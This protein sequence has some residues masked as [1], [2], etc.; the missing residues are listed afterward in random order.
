MDFILRLTSITYPYS[1]LLE[2]RRASALT[3]LV[4]MAVG[5]AIGILAVLVL[6]G[7]DT[8][9]EQALL[10]MS[11]VLVAT[12]I[13]T[14]YFGNRGQLRLASWIYVGVSMLAS[15]TLVVL[16]GLNTTTLMAL[17]I[18]Y[19]VGG[20]V[21]DRRGVV[22]VTAGLL[23]GLVVAG[24]LELTVFNR[25]EDTLVGMIAQPALLLIFFGI[26]EWYLLRQ[27]GGSFDLI[28]Q[29]EHNLNA[30]YELSDIILE[31][32][33]V[34]N[35]LREYALR[36]QRSMDLQQVL[37]YM[38]DE[39]R[40]GTLRLRAAA[41]LAAQRAL[42]DERT[43]SLTSEQPV[44]T[45]AKT[46][47]PQIGRI[48]DLANTRS[49]FFPGTNAE[50]AIP[51]L[52]GTRLLGVIDLHSAF[53]DAFGV[54]EVESNLL[55]S[56]QLAFV[57][58][59]LRLTAELEHASTDQSQ[60]QRQIAQ[61]SAEAQR[62]RRQ[63]SGT[64]WAEFFQT[65]D[66]GG[67]GFDLRREDPE[68]VSGQGLTPA[69]TQALETGQVQVE[70][71]A[72]GHR[73]TLPILMRGETLGAMEFDIQRP[74]FLPERLVELASTVAERLSLSLDNA[75]LVEQAQAVAF[76]EQQVS[77][78]SGRLQVTS[79]M[80]ELITLAA[81]EFSEALDGASTHIRMQI[82][83]TPDS[84]QTPQAVPATGQH[85]GGAA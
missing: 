33:S 11:P 22:F 25:L 40:P 64:V 59:N 75:R 28:A 66:R 63:T 20:L 31:A 16:S 32:D 39:N 36:A 56:R 82:D 3:I 8:S 77:N 62:L 67:L 5:L 29:M 42:L 85:E 30:S 49:G 34:D 18:P 26:A 35:L 9:R 48:T 60:L 54:Q 46:H 65:R 15:L 80:E 41:G 45:A 84:S 69:M 74:G 51:L 44:T 55:I 17:A 43:L 78:I 72:Q 70:P 27:M 83:D 37:I 47:E 21:L 53:V 52:E 76:R 61:L 57:L 12:A 73:L 38:V 19:F 10:L 2:Q 23:G 14:L 81:A 68:P 24:V 71:T 58:R 50:L 7:V 4:R 79:T 13:G 6:T 1:N